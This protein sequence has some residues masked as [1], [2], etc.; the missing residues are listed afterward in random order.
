MCNVLDEVLNL[1]IKYIVYVDYEI[2]IL[3][4]EMF[5]VVYVKE[6]IIVC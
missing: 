4:Y 1:W 3:G 6:L 5:C 2:V